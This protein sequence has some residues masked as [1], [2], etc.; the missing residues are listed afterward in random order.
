[1]VLKRDGRRRHIR[2]VAILGAAGGVGGVVDVLSVDVDGVGYKGRTAVAAAGVALL[3]AKELNLG[4][5]TLEQGF[6]HCVDV[7]KTT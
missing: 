6:A 3:K 1:M 5:D 7:K 2:V 4:L